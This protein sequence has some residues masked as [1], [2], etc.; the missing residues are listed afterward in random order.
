LLRAVRQASK[1]LALETD[2]VV[3]DGVT[4]RLHREGTFDSLPKWWVHSYGYESKEAAAIV[5]QQLMPLGYTMTPHFLNYAWRLRGPLLDDYREVTRLIGFLRK[6]G[7]TAALVP[8]CTNSDE[9]NMPRYWALLKVSAK[10]AG[11][12]EVRPVI[13]PGGLAALAPLKTMIQGNTVALING[14]Y[15]NI[16]GNDVGWPIGA[17]LI[18]REL[19]NPPYSGRSAMAWKD[20]Q[21][22][23][24]FPDLDRTVQLPENTL[25]IK[26]FNYKSKNS[27]LVLYNQ[28]F[29]QSTPT[30]DQGELTELVV[31]DGRVIIKNATGGTEIQP[32]DSI[33]AAYNPLTAYVLDTLRVGDSVNLNLKLLSPDPAWNDV[34][35]AIQAGPMLV[36]DRQLVPQTEMEGFDSSFVRL[37]HPRTVVGHNAEGDWLFFVGDGR[38]GTHSVG[39]SLSETAAILQTLGALNAL[40]LDGGGS[41]EMV[42]RGVLYN[43]PSEG[44]ERPISYGLAVVNR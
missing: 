7:K 36:R 2:F 23:F 38:D 19:A 17:L 35:H 34:E 42:I 43:R 20:H 15:F 10:N 32:G 12:L 14:G 8:S 26:A 13:A 16:T 28:F 39:Y 30:F 6:A 44:R 40:N 11:K 25:Q 4:L 3:A 27:D 18:N 24:G 41:T 22:V 33:L 9:E 31:R 37:R 1:G 29:V 21:F 5:A